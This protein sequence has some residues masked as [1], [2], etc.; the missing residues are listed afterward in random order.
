MDESERN[1]WLEERRSGIGGSDAAAVLGLSPWTTPFEVYQSKLGLAPPINESW[2]MRWGNWLEP[3][4]RQ[5]YSDLTGREVLM[6]PGVIRHPKHE[7]MLATLDGH[8]P[9]GRL[10]EIKTSRSADGWGEPGSADIPQHY[11]LQVQHYLAVTAYPVADVVLG[12]YGQEPRIYEVPADL[13]LQQLMLE[14]EEAFWGNV[15]RSEPPEPI[16]LADA[17][18]RYGKRSEARSVVASPDILHMA[19][20]LKEVSVLIKTL[21]TEIDEAK[22]QIMA[23]LAEADTLVDATGTPL[24]TWKMAKPSQ[25]FDAGLFKAQH[26]DLYKQFTQPGEASRRFLI[27]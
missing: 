25:R 4:L 23:A 15:Q 27:K 14:Q 2:P 17:M 10:V 12:L 18:A 8:T 24:V 9:D 21:N 22:G 16:T 1:K 6:H 11:M 5:S 7:W 26:P 19:T 3:H 20:R 13:E